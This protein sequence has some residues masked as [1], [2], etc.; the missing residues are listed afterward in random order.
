MPL[1]FLESLQKLKEKLPSL[2][3]EN[4]SEEEIAANLS[5]NLLNPLSLKGTLVDASPKI[6]RVTTNLVHIV[7]FLFLVFFSISYF[8][9]RQL[10][11]MALTRDDLI[12]KIDASSGVIQQAREVT[13]LIDIYKNST[14]AYPKTYPILRKVLDTFNKYSLIKN[15]TYTRDQ[16]YFDVY[17]NSNS[18][19]NYALLI[20]D[21]LEV[22]GITEVVIDS[23]NLKVAR[24]RNFEARL[25]VKFDLHKTLYE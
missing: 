21:L 11:T 6:V 23:V 20:N 10:N 9:D 22:E 2:P 7:A 4:K 5:P 12:L 19:L 1:K 25:Q 15:I 18:A 13:E 24:E 3:A 16:N 8:L 17:S 14:A